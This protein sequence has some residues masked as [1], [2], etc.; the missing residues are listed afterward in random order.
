MASLCRNDHIAVFN[1]WKWYIKVFSNIEIGNWGLSPFGHTRGRTGCRKSI[2]VFRRWKRVKSHKVNV[3]IRLNVI[4]EKPII[5]DGMAHRITVNEA[6]Y[7]MNI[8]STITYFQL[9]LKS[10]KICLLLT[11]IYP[12]PSSNK[13]DDFFRLRFHQP[14]YTLCS[15]V[16]DNDTDK[17]T[18]DDDRPSCYMTWTCLFASQNWNAIMVLLHLFSPAVSSILL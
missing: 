12:I 11:Y 18:N 16:L 15:I 17:K 7:L 13:W 10:T 5:D 9:C 2:H 8:P 14:K 6:F 3:T 4:L 1:C